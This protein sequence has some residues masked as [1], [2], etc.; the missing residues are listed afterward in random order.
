MRRALI[1]QDVPGRV[2]IGRGGAGPEA[3]VRSAMDGEGVPGVP[4]VSGG[5]GGARGGFGGLQETGNVLGWSSV[6]QGS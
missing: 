3:V 5:P 2:A 6:S 1:G 4:G